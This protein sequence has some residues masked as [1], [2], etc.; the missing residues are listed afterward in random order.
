M[1]VKEEEKTLEEHRAATVISDATAATIIE[2]QL[3]ELK[4]QEE[5]LRASE[6]GRK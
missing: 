2:E 3:K 1:A 6:K 4:E 5:E